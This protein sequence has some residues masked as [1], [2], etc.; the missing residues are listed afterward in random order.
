MERKGEE[1]GDLESDV[2]SKAFDEMKEVLFGGVVVA[3]RGHASVSFNGRN[4]LQLTFSNTNKNT[5]KE[6]IDRYS[7]R[8]VMSPFAVN[9][10]YELLPV[11]F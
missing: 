2:S 10:C 6:T 7:F 3:S 5:E 1:I 4:E 9:D 11:L 8:N